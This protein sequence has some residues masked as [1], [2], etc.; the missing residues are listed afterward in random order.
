MADAAPIMIMVVTAGFVAEDWGAS[1]RRVSSWI[2]TKG[3]RFNPKLLQHTASILTLWRSI[4]CT[5]VNVRH[6]DFIHTSHP[7]R[8]RPLK[9]RRRVARRSRRH[10]AADVY[11]NSVPWPSAG[12]AT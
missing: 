1:R 12:M 6:Q 7:R 4:L 10:S 5:C 2:G 11:N 9:P 8:R 3:Q